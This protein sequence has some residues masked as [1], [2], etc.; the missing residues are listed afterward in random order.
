MKYL[1]ILKDSF[2]EAVDTK[3]F[4]VMIALSALIMLLVSSISFTPQPV[5]ELPELYTTMPLNMDRELWIQLQTSLQQP[6]KKLTKVFTQ[7]KV[8]PAEGEPDSPSSPLHF[9]IRAMYTTDTEIAAVQAAPHEAEDFIRQRFASVGDWK[10]LEVTSVKMTGSPGPKQIVFDVRTRPTRSTLRVWPH[11]PTLFFGAIPLRDLRQLALGFQVWYIEDQLVDAWGAW[12]A[13]LT[14]VILTAF[15]IPNMLRK[16]TI[17]LLLVKPIHRS[18]LLVYKYV[19]GLTF[20]FLNTLVAI[21]GV[22][23]ILSMRS[24]I[25][26]P[27]FLLSVLVI[28]FFFAILYSISTLV[29][30]LTQSPIV[31]IVITCLAWVSFFAVGI[32]YVMPDALRQKEDIEQTAAEHRISD[33]KWVEVVKAIHFVFPRVKDL[34]YLTSQYLYKDLLSGSELTFSTQKEMRFSWT[35]SLCVD[36]AFV[37]FMLCLACWRF[38]R[39]DY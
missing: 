16:G 3:V 7:S 12:L 4:Y 17:D 15:F 22:W 20:I 25:W 33:G 14:S 2:R 35:E 28:T 37:G 26:A 8:E 36:G 21:V 39:R 23:I 5:A 31:A 13:I 32:A 19:G 30:V 27:A 34:D 11:Q 18:T 24:G 1:A 10:I 6:S 29:A 38:A 9:S